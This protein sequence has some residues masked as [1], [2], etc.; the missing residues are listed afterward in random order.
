MSCTGAASWRRWASWT[1]A[2]RTSHS[3]EQ[4]ANGGGDG[5]EDG[6]SLSVQDDGGISHTMKDHLIMIYYHGFYAA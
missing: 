4:P 5:R 1:W 2:Q 3:G 6:A